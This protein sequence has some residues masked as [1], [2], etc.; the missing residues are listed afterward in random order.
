MIS[1]VIPTYNRIDVLLKCLNALGNQTVPTDKYEVIVIDDGSTDSTKSTL[2]KRISNYTFSVRYFYQSNRGPASARNIGIKEAKNSIILFIGDDIIATP[3]LIKE[4]IKS[5]SEYPMENIAILGFTTWSPELVVT[6][7]MNW[8]EN[9]GPQFS[10]NQIEN[11]IDLTQDLEFFFY[12][13]NISLKRSFI[14]QNG[15]FDED[16]P[17][18]AFEDTEYGF[19]LK[20]CGLKLIYN[21]NAVGFHYHP[22][23]IESVSRRMQRV[24]ESMHILFQKQPEIIPRID[25]A[26]PKYDSFTKIK[27]SILNVLFPVC[28]PL[29]FQKLNKSY[30]SSTMAIHLQKGYQKAKKK[31]AS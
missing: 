15:L 18:A 16:F 8:L 10:Y 19:R 24:G 22:M 3:N 12:T 13:S 30:Y 2:D 27:R 7:F 9:G 20:K 1:V 14:L 29:N 23:T 17:S 31:N 21:K 28:R 5:H 26:M 6:P 4:H 11:Q 25:Y